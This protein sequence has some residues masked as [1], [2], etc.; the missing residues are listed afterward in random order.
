MSFILTTEFKHHG[1]IT[2]R[3][4]PKTPNNRKP[5]TGGRNVSIA[6]GRM[7]V[8]SRGSEV[9]DSWLTK[10]VEFKDHVTL[11]LNFKNLTHHLNS[12]TTHRL[13]LM[14]I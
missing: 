2:G 3:M 1:F 4:T 5:H 9:G 8:R 11:N 6:T 14:L 12:Y 7:Y 13:H 10:R